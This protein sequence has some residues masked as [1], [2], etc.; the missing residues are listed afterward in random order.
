GTKDMPIVAM[1]GLAVADLALSTARAT[2]AA[3]MVG[4]AARLRGADD[5]TQLDVK[6]LAAALRTALGDEA[7]EATYGRGRALDR[8][9][10][11]ARLDPAT[12]S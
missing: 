11:I 9:A 6:R 1:V 8:D 5:P 4:A 3:E 2:D 10:A 7:Y 12:L